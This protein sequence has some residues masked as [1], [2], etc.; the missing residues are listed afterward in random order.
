MQMIGTIL[1]NKKKRTLIVLPGLAEQWA[2][3]FLETT[4]HGADLP[5]RA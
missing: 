2:H 1:C 5:W 3:V 4:K